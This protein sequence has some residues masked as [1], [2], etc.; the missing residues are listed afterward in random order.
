ML[1]DFNDG[2]IIVEKEQLDM[3][4]LSSNRLGSIDGGYQDYVETIQSF[5]SHELILGGSASIIDVINPLDRVSKLLNI[6]MSRGGAGLGKISAGL[7][8][9]AAAVQ[10]H[11]KNLNYGDT[12]NFNASLG[13]EPAVNKIYSQ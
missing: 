1:A 2:N 13:Q 6:D 12:M 3:D 5:E 11:N 10:L 4:Y 7:S 9:V 8:A